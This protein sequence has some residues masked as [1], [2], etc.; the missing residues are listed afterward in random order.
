MKSFLY[1]LPVLA[2]SI[3]TSALA[4]QIPY[5]QPAFNKLVGEGK[6]VLVEVYADWCSTC[7]AQASITDA[8]LREKPYRG[9]HSLR[10]DYDKQKDALGTLRVPM[11]STLIL[12]KG[13]KEVGRS[14]GDTSRES[15]ENLLRKAI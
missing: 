6:P 2:I 9:I 12:F 3:A 11:Q 13:G 8:L 7:R 14:L 10:I 4:E 1:F 15:I 5:S